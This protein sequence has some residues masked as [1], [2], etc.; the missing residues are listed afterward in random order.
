MPILFLQKLL[1]KKATIDSELFNK[2][3]SKNVL[4]YILGIMCYKFA[5]ETYLGSISIIAV[6]RFPKENAFTLLG[7]LQGAN[8]ACQCIGSILVAPL[9]SRYPANKILAHSIWVFCIMAIVLLVCEAATG[10]TLTVRGK[11]I[12]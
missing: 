7:G 12:F 8:Q 2:T 5:L 4:L 9:I 11:K 6:E 10:G 1:N 3:E